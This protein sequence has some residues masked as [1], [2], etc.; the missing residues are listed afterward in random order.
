MSMGIIYPGSA[1]VGVQLLPI[2]VFEP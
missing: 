2:W 1:Y